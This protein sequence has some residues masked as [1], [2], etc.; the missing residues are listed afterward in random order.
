M[1]GRVCQ[2][3]RFGAIE[4]STFEK[5]HLLCKGLPANPCHEMLVGELGSPLNRHSKVKMLQGTLP[6]TEKTAFPICLVNEDVQ[7]GGQVDRRP[8]FCESVRTECR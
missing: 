4:Q 1:A 3:C 8:D 7:G 2:A 6:A 5:V